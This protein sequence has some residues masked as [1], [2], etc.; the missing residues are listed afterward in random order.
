MAG[1]GPKCQQD[2]TWVYPPIGTALKMVGLE[3]IGVYIARRHN[4]VTQY[5]LNRTIMDF[6]LAVDQKSGIRLSRQW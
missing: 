1:M 6:C 4:M 3:D 5:I 2:G